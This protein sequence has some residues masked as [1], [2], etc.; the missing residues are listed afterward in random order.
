MGRRFYGMQFGRLGALPS[1][2]IPGNGFAAGMVNKYL[3]L[4]PAGQVLNGRQLIAKARELQ[5]QYSDLMKLPQGAEIVAAARGLEETLA[6]AWNDITS[7]ATELDRLILSDPMLKLAALG[8]RPGQEFLG[9]KMQEYLTAKGTPNRMPKNGGLWTPSYTPMMEDW[10]YAHDALLIEAAAYRSKLEA[11]KLKL[12]RSLAG[13]LGPKL[14]TYVMNVSSAAERIRALD[15]A[16]M[17]N[18]TAIAQNDTARTTLTTTKVLAEQKAVNKAIAKLD[19]PSPLMIAA[20]G[21]PVLGAIWYALKGRK[22]SVAGYRRR[23]RR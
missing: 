3:D 4:V 13:S 18:K 19:G 16:V 22:S 15:H 6:I 8:P 12:D 17:E 2:E 11:L 10:D 5:S 14:I 1:F 9:W 23:S 7:F 20:V 21:I